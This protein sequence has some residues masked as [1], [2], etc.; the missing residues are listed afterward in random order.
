MLGQQVACPAGPQ[1]RAWAPRQPPNPQDLARKCVWVRRR[2]LCA[3]Q[4]RDADFY[5]LK[6]EAALMCFEGVCQMLQTEVLTLVGF[7]LPSYSGGEP[8]RL[9]WGP[10]GCCSDHTG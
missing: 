4:A 7:S 10:W 1:E 5:F 6:L 3:C 9:R 8:D 2:A